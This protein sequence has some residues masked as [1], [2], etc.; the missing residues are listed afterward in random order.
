MTPTSL[1]DLS[2]LTTSQV[3][4]E[5]QQK[6]SNICSN[7]SHFREMSSVNPLMTNQSQLIALLVQQYEANINQG[8]SE[9]DTTFN[10]LRTKRVETIE[11]FESSPMPH[12]NYTFIGRLHTAEICMGSACEIPSGFNMQ[13]V[14]QSLMRMRAAP[15]P[16]MGALYPQLH[17]EVCNKT[18]GL[19]EL[20]LK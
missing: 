20:L 8:G 18:V 9:A 14:R 11:H 4:A 2:F 16:P 19:T 15:A 12:D 10:D 13:P 6:I 3:F 1:T 5:F 17:S 7:L